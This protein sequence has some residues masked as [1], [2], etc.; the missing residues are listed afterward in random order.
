MTHYK[1]ICSSYPYISPQV[2]KNKPGSKSLL[3]PGSFITCSS[4]DTI[5]IWNLDWSLSL[6]N[7]VYKRNIFSRDLL[8]IMYID[9][10]LKFICNPDLRNAKG[11]NEK[12]NDSTYDGKNGVRCLRLSPDSQHLASGDRSGN[13]RIFDLESQ[14]DECK[15]EAHDSE[16]LCL[17]Y[18]EP[19]LGLDGPYF[20]GSASRDRFIHIF[21]VNRRYSFVQTLD[22][23]NSAITSIKF[24]PNAEDKHLQLISCGADKSIIF[25]KMK[26]DVKDQFTRENNVVGKTTLYDMELDEP[27]SHIITAC[28]DRQIRVHSV[29]GGRLVNNFKGCTS[30]DGTLIKVTFDPSG[31]FI[32]TSSTDKTL[33]VVDYATGEIVATASGHSELITGLKFSPNG[34][35]LISVS[36]DGCIFIWKLHSDIANSI[37]EKLGLPPVPPEKPSF[38]LLDNNGTPETTPEEEEL[39]LPTR[40]TSPSNLNSLPSWTKKKINDEQCIEIPELSN[41][42]NRSRANRSERVGGVSGMSPL[43]TDSAGKYSSKAK[44]GVSNGN[45]EDTPSNESVELS[46]PIES[47][48]SGAFA[49]S[50]ITVKHGRIHY[51]NPRLMP[52]MSVPNFNDL[53]S[54]EEEDVTLGSIEPSHHTKNNPLYLST[55]NLYKIDQRKKFLEKNVENLNQIDACDKSSRSSLSAMYNMSHPES[56]AQIVS[57]DMDE[58]SESSSRRLVSSASQVVS[59]VITSFFLPLS[60]SRSID[61]LYLFLSHFQ[62]RSGFKDRYTNSSRSVVNLTNWSSS[63]RRVHPVTGTAS[64]HPSISIASIVSFTLI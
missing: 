1:P 45:L 24:V 60:L 38:L 28:Q 58:L 31:K 53:V 7:Y 8:K 47:T 42:P 51:A 20:L 35:N 22:D 21:D 11:S 50:T 19:G 13:I 43:D 9:P 10:E 59:I 5:R 40:I 49:S 2:M 14:V 29:D 3:P 6:E 52:S 23:H 63:T 56:S 39:P 15:I 57:K 54:D 36:G 55:E 12:I 25:R 48:S 37:S 41:S 26:L 44:N 62:S 61:H 46:S 34:R 30:D 17:E 27:K 32:A 4:D 16:V 33:S 18:N 64:I